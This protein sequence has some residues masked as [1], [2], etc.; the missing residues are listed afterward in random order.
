MGQTGYRNCSGRIFMKNFMR[1]VF[2]KFT[3][4]QENAVSININNIVFV[5]ES[6][7]STCEII[8][9]DGA[10]IS[11]K[12]SFETAIADIARLVDSKFDDHK[13]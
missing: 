11:V 13:K 8:C 9:L 2:I 10:I 6:G 7:H 3:S 4:T 1:P 5:Q 12:G